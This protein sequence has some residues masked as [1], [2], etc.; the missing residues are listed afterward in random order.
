M[1][2]L[3]SVPSFF[4]YSGVPVSLLFSSTEVSSVWTKEI[5][6]VNL[7]LGA[8][9]LDEPIAGP[10]GIS[11]CRSLLYLFTKVNRRGSFDL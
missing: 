8:F 4:S 5:W 11:G 6:V 7:G 1:V 3:L 2:I 9:S 10:G